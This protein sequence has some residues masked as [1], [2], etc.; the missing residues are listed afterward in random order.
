MAAC[1]ISCRPL[2]TKVLASHFTVSVFSWTRKIL[3]GS[4][5]TGTAGATGVSN[6]T[7]EGDYYKLGSLAKPD[8]IHVREEFTVTARDNAV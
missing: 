5:T 3:R 7:A 8:Q 4:S 6:S 2:L 1:L